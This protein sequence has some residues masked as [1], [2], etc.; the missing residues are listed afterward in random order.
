MIDL[1]TLIEEVAAG[2]QPVELLE[3]LS[4]GDN[5]DL[6]GQCLRILVMEESHY[7]VREICREIIRSAVVV[8]HTQN[9][10]LSMEWLACNQAELPVLDY[11]IT[12]AYKM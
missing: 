5:V 1:K 9:A 2:R 6:F 4:V 8:L 10:R 3:E 12:V 7:Q 11:Q